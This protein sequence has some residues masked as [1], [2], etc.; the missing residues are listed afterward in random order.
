MLVNRNQFH[1][2]W[3]FCLESSCQFYFI[4]EPLLPLNKEENLNWGHTN[5]FEMFSWRAGSL[6]QHQPRQL[7]QCHWS[8]SSVKSYTSW[9]FDPVIWT[10]IQECT[11]LRH[12]GK[13]DSHVVWHKPM[14]WPRFR[15]IKVCKAVVMKTMSEDKAVLSWNCLTKAGLT[16]Q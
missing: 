8:H 16:E 12:W 5:R 7:H 6:S 13:L 4:S 11:M 10:V 1:K 15:L 3:W 2:K 9:G 14:I